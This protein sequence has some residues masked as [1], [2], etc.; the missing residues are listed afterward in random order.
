MK[1]K[2]KIEMTMQLKSYRKL[3]C[4]EVMNEASEWHTGINDTKILRHKGKQN[5]KL[6]PILILP[7]KVVQDRSFHRNFNGICRKKFL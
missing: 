1:K 7:P 4:R 2:H 3:E 6:D 5:K